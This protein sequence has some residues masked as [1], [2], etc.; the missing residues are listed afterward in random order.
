MSKELTNL[1][2]KLWKVFSQYI[3]RRDKGVCFTCGLKKHWK[4]QQAGHMIPKSVGGLSLY[5][6]ELNV[7]VQCYRCNINLGGNGAIYAKNFVEK[8]GQWKFDE[9]LQEKNKIVKFSKQ[10][11]LFLL[12]HYINLL[13]EMDAERK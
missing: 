6:H 3:R 11:Y 7:N 9:L 2:K 5:F 12:D 4:E 8:Y 13:K 1:K 10:H